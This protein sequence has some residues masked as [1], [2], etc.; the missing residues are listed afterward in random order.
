MSNL[1]LYLYILGIFLVGIGSYKKIKGTK[2][3]YVA[4]GNAG[5]V[6]ITGSLLATILGSSA[7]IGSVNFSTRNGWAGSWFMI[8]AA[9]GLGVL[10]FLLERL[11]TFK[12]YNLP[13]LLGSFYG[14]EVNKIASFVIPIAWTG[15]VA[16]QIMG[17]AMI[18]SKMTSITYTSGIWISGLVFIAYT[19]LGGQFSIIKTDFIQFLFIILGLLFCFIYTNLNYD[20]SD[21]LP[22]INDKFGY[23]EL[24]VMLLTYSTTF[25]V[26]PDIY[27]RIFCAK[28][29]KTAKKA[30]IL[31]IIILLP[32][33]YILSSLGI[34]AS[35]LIGDRSVDSSLI[36]LIEEILPNS[37]AVLM[38]FCLLSAVISSA[39]TTLLTAS[40]M[41]T[42]IFIGD[43]KNKRSIAITRVFIIVLGIISIYIALKMKFI[44]SSIF[45][46]FSIYSG[47]FII[48]TFLGIL[49]YRACKEYIILAI[50]AGGGL[51]L[52]GKIY[53]GQNGN[54][55]I[56][57]AFILNAFILYIPYFFKK[58]KEEISW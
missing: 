49:G 40:S 53:G 30:I 27:S 20:L 12:G 42:Q 45:L 54:I 22:L 57:L 58:S 52:F 4:G 46:A 11:K 28:D 44:L 35:A 8:C 26:G 1:L 39:D 6:P 55:Y 37:I 21:A 2:D 18:I 33:S 43:L 14:I 13:E 51:A 29:T 47:A 50:F 10:Y 23:K 7:I 9:L 24:I 19:C 38:Y 34:H 5:V 32:L 56:I 16:S 48:P 31:S 15:I 41:L 36:F 17:A 25:F 3:F